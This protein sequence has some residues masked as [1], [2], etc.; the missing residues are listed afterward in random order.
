[1]TH[2]VAPRSTEPGAPVAVWDLPTRLFHW[3]LVLLVAAAWWTAEEEMHEWHERTG[4]AILGLVTFRIVW[5]VI[6]SSTARFS[7]FVKGPRGIADYLRGRDGTILGHN[8][9]GALSVIALLVAVTV[10]LGL[11][12]FASDEDGLLS[13]PFAHWIS[14][15]AAEEVAELHEAM[16]DVLLILIGIHVAAILFY[17]IV[18]RDN[19]VGPMVHGR[20][21]APEGTAPMEEAPLWRLIAAMAVAAAVVWIVGS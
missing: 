2:I 12:L 13:G 19:L 15:E 21:R 8:P 18:K 9:I 10:Q 11:G 16:F 4:L 20:R 14:D 1:M 17:L 7:G 3:A 6:G 5:G